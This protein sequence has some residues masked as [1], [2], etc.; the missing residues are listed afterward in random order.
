M[1]TIAIAIPNP[2]RYRYQYRYRYRFWKKISVS[3]KKSD[4]G[5]VSI[6]NFFDKFLQIYWNFFRA[7]NEEFIPENLLDFQLKFDAVHQISVERLVLSVLVKNINLST[8]IQC[9][10]L[11]CGWW[12]DN[13]IWSASDCCVLNQ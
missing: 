2:I 7:S 13:P 11:D 1:E 12:H 8:E 3:K 9:S 10:A 5:I 4:F 6:S